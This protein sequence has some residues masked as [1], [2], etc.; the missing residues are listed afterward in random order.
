MN[1]KESAQKFGS[2]KI[3]NRQWESGPQFILLSEGAGLYY[4]VS[5]YFF[6]VGHFHIVGNT[7]DNTMRRP[8]V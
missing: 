6:K 4:T 8:M 7:L 1:Q 2:G 3:I 5:K